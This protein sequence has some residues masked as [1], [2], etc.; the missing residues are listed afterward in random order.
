MTLTRPPESRFEDVPGYPYDPAFVDVGGPE[1]AY[2]EAGDP[3]SEETFLCLHGEPT[4]GYLYR[5]MIPT[6]AEEGRVI[7]PDFVGFGRSD[8]YTDLDDYTFEMFYETLTT[9]IERLDLQNVTLV[10]QDWGGVIGLPVA[11][12]EHPE[13]VARL[14]PMN[15]GTPTGKRGM[16]DAWWGFRDYMLETEDPPVSTVIRAVG[17]FQWYHEQDE[18]PDPW[19]APVEEGEAGLDLDP[20]V[21]A[22]YDAPFPTPESKAGARKWPSLVPTDTGMDGAEIGQRAVAALREWEKPSFV[23][24]SDSDPVTR[25]TRDA[26]RN[27]IP[28]ADAQPDVWIE[29]A[30]HFLQEEAG[31]EV[32]EEIVGFV[33]RT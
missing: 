19:L 4:W 21:A 33:R 28:S 26:Y 15:T 1:M 30:G 22:A 16:I 13:R 14:V 2:V 9:F 32:A 7:V 10:C 18:Q 12:L 3:D 25:E 23:L 6:L 20:A 11:V 27:L 29:G 17:D 24:F 8:T 31:E 5:K